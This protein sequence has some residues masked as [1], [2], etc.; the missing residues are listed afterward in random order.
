MPYMGRS[1]LS[2]ESFV[3]TQVTSPELFISSSIV[4][5]SY[6]WYNPPILMKGDYSICLQFQITLLV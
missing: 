5:S 2:Q 1:G 3:S 6:I 4:I